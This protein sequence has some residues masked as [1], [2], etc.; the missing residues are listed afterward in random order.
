MTQ[1]GQRFSLSAELGRGV[2]CGDIGVFV[3][4]VPLLQWCRNS[5][6]ADE[7]QLRAA[8]GLNRDL[9]KQYDI[10]I[11]I[12][13][14]MAG[15]ATV[16]RALNRGDL[17][18][19]Q[20]AML[21]LQIPDPPISTKS[22]STALDKIGLARAL[23]AS[24][25]IKIQEAWDD[26]KHPRW[27][28]GSPDSVGGQFA[29]ADTGSADAASTEQVAVGQSAPMTTAQS[30][31]IVVPRYAPIPFP[32]EIPP[33]PLA[34]DISPRRELQNPYPDRPECQ[35]E[36]EHAF[37]YCWNLVSKGLLGTDGHRG[38]GSSFYKCVLG[39]VS[40]ACGGNPTA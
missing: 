22:N 28:A 31:T 11:E 5:S 25:L 16:C 8:A 12:G 37:K 29:P 9:S 26:E 2:F 30:G 7:W 3:G 32:K 21:H 14:K 15:L 6:G 36:W 34:P 35:E 38:A 27:P 39:Q 40:E 4:G 23:R 10:I 24:G 20:I 33:I 17:I 13:G 18:H 1:I 19:A